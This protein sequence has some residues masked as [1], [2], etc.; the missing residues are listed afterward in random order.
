MLSENLLPGFSKVTAGVPDFCGKPTDIKA[1][2]ASSSKY[3]EKTSENKSRIFCVSRCPR[4]FLATI[5]SAQTVVTAL[6]LISTNQR[7]R[8]TA[9][10]AGEHLAAGIIRFLPQ[11]SGTPAV[12]R[13]FS[14]SVIIPQ[15]L[16][17]LNI[18]ISDFTSKKAGLFARPFCF[19]R[20]YFQAYPTLAPNIGP[21]P[22]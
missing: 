11:K 13:G 16:F 21:M 19:T 1:I 3:G 8:N 10:K 2:P 17:F 15:Q 14:A 7:L 4:I 5:A 6:P 22:P 12:T 9:R 20:F 18:F